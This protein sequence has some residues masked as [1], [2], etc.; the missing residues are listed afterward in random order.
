MLVQSSIYSFLAGS[1]VAGAAGNRPGR[2]QTRFVLT[3]I[4]AGRRG[5][6]A[7]VSIVARLGQWAVDAGARFGALRK[8]VAGGVTNG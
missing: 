2:A 8:G 4:N 6:P 3:V 7:L 1:E 5:G